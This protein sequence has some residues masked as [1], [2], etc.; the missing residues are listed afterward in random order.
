M[1]LTLL[2]LLFFPE[3][4][5]IQIFMCNLP[6]FQMLTTNLYFFKKKEKEKKTFTSQTEHAHTRYSRWAIIKRHVRS[7]PDPAGGGKAL[8]CGAPA[9]GS[10][11]GFIGFCNPG[12]WASIS[13]E[14]WG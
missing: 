7:W 12:L 11:P 3:K 10:N 13:S 4:P 1:G 8:R 14:K 6:I 2:P 9:L 5:E